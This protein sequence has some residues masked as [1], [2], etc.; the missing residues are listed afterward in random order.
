MRY[1]RTVWR[2]A[3][4]GVAGFAAAS[5][6]LPAGAT[7]PGVNGRIAFAADR[8]AAPGIDDI[9]TM[10]NNG[11]RVI[12][13]THS[14]T[15]DDRD[16]RWSPDGTRIAFDSTRTGRQGV[17]VI[18]ETGHQLHRI[19]DGSSPAWSPDGAKV[20]FV[21]NGT[22]AIA[23]RD[24]SGYR[25]LPVSLPPATLQSPAWSPDGRTIVYADVPVITCC[26]ASA[27]PMNTLWL[28]AADGGSPPRK[29]V[30]AT[31]LVRPTW[32]PDGQRIFATDAQSG[33]IA[34]VSVETAAITNVA[35]N[36]AASS[37]VVSP[38]CTRI[39]YAGLSDGNSDI[40]T[41]RADGSGPPT[42]VTTW[43][44]SEVDPDWQAFRPAATPVSC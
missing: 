36:R 4:L 40:W 44:G 22:L 2:L 25:Q 12:N 6:A 33:A 42:R 30:T 14:P 31:A 38:D 26:F 8:D 11:T 41:M 17:Y 21:T 39:A 13:L 35:L 16:P 20:V 18:N 23:G 43:P 37:A 15:E 19:H 27:P 7:F 9:F 3:L 29:L 5:A 28:V 1:C 32:S 34:S 24:G 10:L